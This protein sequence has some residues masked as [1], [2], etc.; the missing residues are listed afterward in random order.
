ML[1]IAKRINES[2]SEWLNSESPTIKC[3]R[4]V[5]ARSGYLYGI[6]GGYVR[7]NVLG[8]KYRDIDIAV[9]CSSKDLDRIMTPLSQTTSDG[10]DIIRNGLGGYKIQ[11]EGCVCVDIWPLEETVTLRD[12]SDPSFSQLAMSTYLTINSIV[13]SFRGLKFECYVDAGFSES[14]LNQEIGLK[15]SHNPRKGICVNRAISVAKKT[16]FRFTTELISDLRMKAAGTE[17]EAILNQH[18]S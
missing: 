5:L 4:E 13:I 18:L 15:Q 10:F 1:N 11:K 12:V 14:I 6:V 7:D 16:G 3:T 8:Y 9:K 2:C 17:K